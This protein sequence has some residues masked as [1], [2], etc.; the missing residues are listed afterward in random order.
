MTRE[1]GSTRDADAGSGGGPD[2]AR[3][4]TNCLWRR[5]SN[6]LLAALDLGALS[7]TATVLPAIVTVVLRADPVF[8]AAVTFTDPLPDSPAEV[9]QAHPRARRVVR[10]APGAAGGSRHGHRTWTRQSAANESDVVETL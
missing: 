5:A 3:W 10:G 9:P 6:V 8:A 1:R 7:L 2:P 4:S